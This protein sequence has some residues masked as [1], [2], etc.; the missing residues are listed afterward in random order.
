M[1]YIRLNCNEN[2]KNM[3]KKLKKKKCLENKLKIFLK[4]Y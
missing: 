4:P 3:L 1:S 2:N